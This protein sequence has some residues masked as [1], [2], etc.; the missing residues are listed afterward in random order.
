[1]IWFGIEHWA[2]RCAQVAVIPLYM[3]LTV[4]HIALPKVV[5]DRNVQLL[6]WSHVL[7]G[8]HGKG[9]HIGFRKL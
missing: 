2:V 4:Q 7:P 3:E 1:M 5:P 9:G 6:S 8:R